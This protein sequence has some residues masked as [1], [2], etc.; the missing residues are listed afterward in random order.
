V[1]DPAAAKKAGP[2]T[3]GTINRSRRQTSRRM[4]NKKM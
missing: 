1:I 3:L 4:K 2:N